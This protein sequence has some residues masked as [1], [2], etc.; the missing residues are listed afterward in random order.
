MI[1]YQPFSKLETLRLCPPVV[2]VP[3]WTAENSVSII[4]RDQTYTL[5]PKVN[6][7]L[8]V[9]ALH[10][11]EEYWGPDVASFNPRRWDKSNHDSFL[12]ANDGKTGLSGP[13]LE[14]EN[15][16][17][18]VRGAFIPFSD[19]FRA[20][21][22]KRFSQVEFVAVMTIIL[23]RY[24]VSLGKIDPE[25]SEKFVYRRAQKVLNES[26]TVLTLGMKS[27]VPLLLTERDSKA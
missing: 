20:C 23:S 1:S 26:A 6:I 25:E 22:G 19:G 4:H 11:S 8:N 7:N 5:P 13:G 17:K 2:T 12:A 10:Y 18:P 24:Q 14:F 15:I 16:H 3:K 27:D 9:N 21:L